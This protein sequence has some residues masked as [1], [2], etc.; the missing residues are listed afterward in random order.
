MSESLDAARR[1]STM[2][3][4]LL[5]ISR[6]ETVGFALE[7]ESVLVNDLVEA[8]CRAYTGRASERLIR[9]ARFGGFALEVRVDRVLLQRVLEN[10]LDNAFRYTPP[11]GRIAI[12]ARPGVEIV[13]SN[14]GP[15]IPALDRERIFGKF[16]RGEADSVSRSNAGLGLYFC[17]RALQAHGGAIDLVEHR[18]FPT[19]FR[20]SLPAQPRAA[21]ASILPRLW[22]EPPARTDRG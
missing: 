15:P 20:I 2:I 13:I 17:R 8:V 5:A 22:T 19:S 16:N 18:D 12:E 4:D 11:E 10:I 9:F 1:L 7:A 6:M 3:S 14:D 21:A